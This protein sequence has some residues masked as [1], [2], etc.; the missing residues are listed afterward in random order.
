M[1]YNSDNFNVK[2]ILIYWFLDYNTIILSILFLMI[3][4]IFSFFL[5]II[6]KQKTKF[7]NKNEVAKQMLHLIIIITNYWNGFASVISNVIR[8]YNHVYLKNVCV[9]KKFIVHLHYRLVI[10]FSLYTPI[11]SCWRKWTLIARPVHGKKKGTNLQPILVLIWNFV[12]F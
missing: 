2:K 8:E 5:N 7:L 6:S 12:L 11:L 10:Y 1:I 9:N 3:L 4:L